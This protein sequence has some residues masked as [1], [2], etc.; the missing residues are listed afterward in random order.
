MT[1]AERRDGRGAPHTLGTRSTGRI[2]AELAVIFAGVFGAF[3]A[4]DVRQ[5][6]E[7]DQRAQQIYAALLGELGAFSA[8][9]P[10][11]TQEM[12]DSLTAFRDARRAGRTVPPAYYREP[13]AEAPPTAIWQATLA[14]G[15]VALLEP[16]LFN[17]LA[18]FY[19]RLESVIGRYR[20]YNTFTEEH[21][22][23]HLRTGADAFYARDGTLAGQYHGHMV[24]LEEIR[25]DL[26]ELSV[27]VREIEGRIQDV[28]RD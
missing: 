1:Q 20:R 14:S 17:E 26:E 28:L 11:V 16:T 24:R 6:R 27:E 25:S 15:G 8:R 2:I 9:V 10:V 4:E 21:V 19:N 5:Q 3:V 7:D 13:R 23:P 18:T 12:D 22:I